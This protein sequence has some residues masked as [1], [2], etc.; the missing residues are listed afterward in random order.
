MQFIKDK[1]NLIKIEILYFVFE[2]LYLAS[3]ANY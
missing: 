3:S 1:K 2:Y